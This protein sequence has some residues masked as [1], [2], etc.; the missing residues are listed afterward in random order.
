M[1]II[2][3]RRQIINLFKKMLVLNNIAAATVVNLLK[4]KRGEAAP[5]PEVCYRCAQ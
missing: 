5:D 2:Q 1:F 3:Q 4:F